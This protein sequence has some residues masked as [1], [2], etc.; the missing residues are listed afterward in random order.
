MVGQAHHDLMVETTHDEHALQ[1]YVST[2]R[3]HILNEIG[4]GLRGVYEN[5]VKP[6]FES[7]KGRA[8][9]DEHEVRRAMMEDGYCRTWSSMMR[10]CQ[11]MIWDSIT[12]FIERAQPGLKRCQ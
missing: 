1:T 8:P 9:K 4:G 12:P 7:M 6:D 2:L 11:E 5:R 3:M 10:S